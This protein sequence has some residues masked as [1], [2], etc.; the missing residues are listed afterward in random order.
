[1]TNCCLLCAYQLPTAY[2]RLVDKYACYAQPDFNHTQSPASTISVIHISH[3]LAL[4]T[5]TVSVLWSIGRA[6]REQQVDN[7]HEPEIIVAQLLYDMWVRFYA[8]T[9]RSRVRIRG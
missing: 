7:R 4:I 6:N 9:Q 8:R 2:G 5:T 3:R 1:M